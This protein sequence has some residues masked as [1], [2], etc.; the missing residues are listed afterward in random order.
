[1]AALP[2]RGWSRNACHSASR[3]AHKHCKLRPRRFRRKNGPLQTLSLSIPWRRI[4]GVN[5]WLHSLISAPNENG[6]PHAPAAAPPSESAPGTYW[7]GLLGI[8]AGLDFLKRKTCGI[9]RVCSAVTAAPRQTSLR[10]D[11]EET[12]RMEETVDIPTLSPNI[13]SACCVKHCPYC[14]HNACARTNG[15]SSHPPTRFNIILLT[16]AV[17]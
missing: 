6:Q 1:M 11:R 15:P 9:E 8:R 5:V 14:L 3:Y 4:A 13:C 12:N 2:T 17:L 7:L 10:V 16:K